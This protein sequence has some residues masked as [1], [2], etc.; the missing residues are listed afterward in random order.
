MAAVS[1]CYAD[2]TGTGVAMTPGR[3]NL[4]SIL[5]APSPARTRS[6]FGL[7]NE[8]LRE[9][10]AG[11]SAPAYRVRQLREALY[12]EWR[13]DLNDLT[14]FPKKLRESMIRDGFAVG[15][16][17]IVQTF[18]S[19]D[20]TE[21]YLIAGNDGQTVETVWMPEGDEGEAGDGSDAGDEES[22]GGRSKSQRRKF[23]ARRF[24][25]RARSVA[26]STASSVSRP[27]WGFN[28]I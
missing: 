27:D 22:D 11:F 9:I 18:R 5:D 7:S 21:R 28:A 6:L 16:P 10:L 17:E 12:R 1:G 19:S 20:G 25:C 3:D 15:L 8:Q 24:A 23:I 2:E 4:F 26:R 13:T 14:T